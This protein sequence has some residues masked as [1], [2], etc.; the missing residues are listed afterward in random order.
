MFRL[1][2]RLY[3]VELDAIREIV[4]YQGVTRLP[5]APR[6]VIGLTNVRGTVVTVID[7]GMRV[8]GVSSARPDGVLMLAEHGGKLVGIAV[9]EV[10]DVQAV[11]AS[12]LVAAPAEPADLMRALGR[13][14]EDL[15]AVLD[16]PAIIGRVLL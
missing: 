8:S 14:D 9:E 15:I 11:D 2:S 5:G 4:P 3:G 13:V 16:V 10:T 7:L 12:R 6:E 1:G